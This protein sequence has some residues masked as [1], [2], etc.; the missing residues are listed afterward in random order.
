MKKWFAGMMAGALAAAM[1]V[2]F[3]ACGEDKVDAESVVGSKVTEEQ[4]D[5][6]FDA[7]TANSARFADVFTA[8]TQVVAEGIEGTLTQYGTWSKYGNKERMQADYS[9]SGKEPVR[10]LPAYRGESF[11]ENI[12]GTNYFYDKIKDLGQ[13]EIGSN[14]VEHYVQGTGEEKWVKSEFYSPMWFFGQL[15]EVLIQTESG[16]G[17]ENF[18]YDAER[19]GY[20]VS[21]TYTPT[22][23]SGD[24]L[25]V[26]F[27][28][29]GR[30]SAFSYHYYW[31]VQCVVE[32]T[33][34]EIK[35]PTVE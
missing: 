17:F 26:K 23:M 32:Y 31:D 35:L 19:K 15:I 10:G 21:E 33:A 25:I 27:D 8:R 22:G 18:N 13:W 9:Y 24:D 4:W 11:M 34:G 1:C 28:E 20:I 12:D 6:A 3:A 16:A 14:G 2:S 29:E 30:I 7:L 5:A